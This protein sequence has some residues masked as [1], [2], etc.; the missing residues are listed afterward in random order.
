MKKP[1]YESELDWREVIDPDSVNVYGLEYSV[2]CS[3]Y[4]MSVHPDEC[5]SE[6]TKTVNKLAG[7]KAGTGH[8]NFEKGCIVEFDL[9]MTPKMS[10]ELERYHFIDFISSQSTMHKITCMD[11]DNAYIKWTDQRCIDVIKE[12]VKEYNSL[13]L[14]VK[15]GEY[16][17]DLYLRILYSNPCGMR[18]TAG[19]VTNYLQLKTIYKQR[20][21]HRLPEW[22]AF[23]E[24]IKTLPHSEW[25]IG[26][27][28]E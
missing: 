24:W 20:H 1:I 2:R 22:R 14:D 21:N 28:D 13:P 15:N 26:E 12:L 18:L 23:C 11:L 27:N 9:T 8:N 19:M 25:I 16:G 3:K 4:P 6:I 10:V 17:K 7:T 5:N